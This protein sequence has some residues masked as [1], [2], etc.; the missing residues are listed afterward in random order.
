[1]KQPGRIRKKVTEEEDDR[2][3]DIAD[4]QAKG[5]KSKE[6][7]KKEAESKKKKRMDRKAWTKRRNTFDEDVFEFIAKHAKEKLRW[8]E[9]CCT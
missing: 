3:D 4:S 7:N 1:M 8:I 5:K 6:R 2:E 9:A